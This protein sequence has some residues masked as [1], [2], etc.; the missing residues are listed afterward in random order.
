MDILSYAKDNITGA[1]LKQSEK[2]S[3]PR[4]MRVE[5][6]RPIIR[7]FMREH[8]EIFWFSHQYS[9]NQKTSEVYFRYDFIPD[10]K[11][12]FSNEISKVVDRIFQWVKL[13]GMS[14]LEKVAYVYKW[15]VANTT[16]NPNSSYNQTIFSVLVNRNSACTGYAKTAQYLLGK[17]GIESKL[18][19]GKFNNDE[20]D[21]GR[22]C[23]NIVKIDED[24]YHVDFCLADPVLNHLLSP[25]E[26]PMEDD[27]VLWNYFCRSSDLLL[28]NRSIEEFE[29]YPSCTKNIDGPVTVC[30]PEP[31]PHSQPEIVAEPPM[32]SPTL[33]NI[34][35]EKPGSSFHPIVNE[36]NG[37]DSL[38]K[39]IGKG[40]SG[41]FGRKK[42]RKIEAC[43]YAPGGVRI[44]EHFVV[45]VFLYLPKLG[46]V[47]D[48]K[49]QEIDARAVKKEY[50]PLSMPVKEGDRITI[51]LNLSDGVECSAPSKSINWDGNMA[52]SS[53]MCTL[54]DSKLP[55]VGGTVYLY[56]N[57]IPT[58]EMLFTIDI[59]KD[60]SSK[61][62]QTY[63]RVSSHRFS[64]IFISYAHEDE[65]QV[66]GIAEG[67]RMLGTDYFFD[68]HTLKAGDLFKEKIISYIDEADLFVLCWSRNAAESEWVRMEREHAIAIIDQGNTRLSIYPLSLRP[69]AP[70]PPDMA[71]RFNFGIL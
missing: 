33:P 37:D 11:A 36:N 3:L 42:L 24:W 10:K 65:L 68:R 67:C 22:H 15:I 14:E 54:K 19:F 55:T 44:H 70:L 23:W 34:N 47:I 29:K 21:Y 51:C 49:M 32:S 7:T 41:I 46:K 61:S 31:T 43:V 45:R 48:A 26:K 5:D 71:G 6:V 12:F 50:V 25:D 38:L 62:G 60:S 35:H 40:F 57:D 9:V 4:G 2:A 1:I 30:F 17:I 27:G 53:F 28:K 63:A 69:E 64:K 52:E 18:I 39:K 16:Y 58:G 13:T 56:V 66:K 59:I 8:P 20:S